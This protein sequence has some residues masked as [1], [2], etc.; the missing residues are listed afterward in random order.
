MSRGVAR[1]APRV[2]CPCWRSRSRLLGRPRRPGRLGRQPDRPLTSTVFGSPA[3]AAARPPRAETARMPADRRAA[4][5]LDLHG[6]RRRASSRD[7]CALS[8]DDRATRRANAAFSAPRDH[9]GRP[10]GPRHRR[11]RRRPGPRRR[12]AADRGRARKGRIPMTIWTKIYRSRSMSAATNT[13]FEHIEPNITFPQARRAANRRLR[14]LR[15]VR[16]GGAGNQSRGHGRKSRKARR[17]Q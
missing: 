16:S 13:T 10:A 2:A 9:E 11:P 3:T 12:A 14:D 6:L 1:F 17:A 5:R 4:G 7:Q 8:G 15:R